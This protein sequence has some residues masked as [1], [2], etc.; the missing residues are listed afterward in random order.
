MEGS[1]GAAR[2]LTGSDRTTSVRRQALGWATAA[3]VVV[4]AL[5]VAALL[6]TPDAID[7]ASSLPLAVAFAVPGAIVV[8]QRIGE[9]VG[10]LLLAIGASFVARAATSAAAG[11]G[12][13]VAVWGAWA[14]SWVSLINPVLLLIVLPQVFP[15]GR[16]ATGWRG[17]PLR[18][19]TVVL[20][21][22]VGVVALT[23]DVYEDLGTAN[24]V[25][26]EGSA[27]L[28]PLAGVLFAVGI[29]LI[30]LS[31]AAA[32]SRY[33]R[34]T[35]VERQQL[36]WMV[37][38]FASTAL[39]IAAMPVVAG[40]ALLTGGTVDIPEPAIDLTFTVAV[41]VIPV[42][43]TLAIT[44]HGL[45]EIDR[46]I[47]R[48]IAYTLVTVVLLAT[49]GSAVFL[50]GGL[51]RGVA[52]EGA[53]DL[54]VAASTLLAAAI[55]RPALTAIRRAVDRRFNRT[56]YDAERMVAGFSSRLREQVDID[57]VAGELARIAHHA[58]QPSSVKVHL[59]P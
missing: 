13:S 38:G 52:G 28:E 55:G 41:S 44:R 43:M 10:W 14:D 34:A 29:A 19:V 42:A 57:L 36:R 59:L 39:L 4:C 17:A 7:F 9:R 2:A 48:A 56:R 18:I 1:S 8:R 32:V 16:A 31:A 27:W 49:Y 5:L 45:Y 53:G 22:L 51:T 21:L 47:S 30:P 24:P 20:P 37:A 12:G 40:V 26:I 25:G 6:P 11:A 35:G 33:R 50:L 46:V 3:L 15:S 23:P 54:V 58:V